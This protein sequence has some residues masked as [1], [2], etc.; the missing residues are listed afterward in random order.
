[1]IKNSKYKI[2]S[3]ILTVLVMTLSPAV[4]ILLLLYADSRADGLHTNADKIQV[5]T[6]SW[7]SLEHET[8]NLL[9]E[10]V[11]NSDEK[12]W[13]H[14]VRIFDAMLKTFLN[15]PQTKELVVKNQAFESRLNKAEQL[16]LTLKDRI[17]PSISHLTECVKAGRQSDL[18]LFVAGQKEQGGL[19]YKMGYLS[20]KDHLQN[21]DD[22]PAQ[23]KIQSAEQD[24]RNRLV[25]LANDCRSILSMSRNHY[26]SLLDE[27]TEIISNRAAEQIVHTRLVTFA[28]SIAIVVFMV[29]FMARMQRKYH[30]N[31]LGLEQL[32]HHH[33]NELASAKSKIEAIELQNEEMNSQLQTSV[34]HANL[35]TQRAMEANRAKN[36]FLTNMSHAIRIPLSAIIGFSEML[37]EEN[38]SDQQKEQVGMIRDSGSQ[39]LQL[40]NDIIDFSKIEMGKISVKIAG[41]NI[42]NIL[43]TVETL[44][45][46]ATQEKKLKFEIIRNQPLPE[47]IQTDPERLKQCLLNLVSNAVKFTEQ[48]RVSVKV[49]WEKDCD[50][51]FV[52]FDVEDTGAGIA[53]GRLQAIFKPFFHT[54]SHAIRK[55]GG[56][57]LGLAITHHLAE[58]LGGRVSVSSVLNQGSVFT[59]CIP[60]QLAPAGTEKEDA[61]RATLAGAKE[62]KPEQSPLQ[63]QAV[64]SEAEKAP[65]AQPQEIAPAQSS[66]KEEAVPE[67]ITNVKFRG[68][69]LIAE[70][71]LTNQALA[72]LLLKKMNLET[73]IVEN[74][75]LAIEK[76]MNE[77][78]DLVLMDIQMPVMNGYE[79]TKA[80]REKG[81]G[82]PIIAL[83]A[84]A[85]KGD[86]EKCFAAGCS[87]YLSKPIDRKK[88]VKT[89]SKYLSK[90]DTDRPETE[91]KE[92]EKNMETLTQQT[93]QNAE[94]QE[95]EID[96]NLLMDRIG[97]E[98]LIDEIIPIFIK[99][100]AERILKLEQAVGKND[101]SEVKFFAHSLKGAAGTVGAAKLSEL[102][103]KLEDDARNSDNSDF[104]PLFEEMKVRF[105]RLIAFF[106]KSDWKEIAKEASS[107]QRAGKS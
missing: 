89:L 40:V 1:M 19:L 81:I 25:Q 5:L 75:E 80:M 82:K 39:L 98:E 16:W 65:A 37:S 85:M 10:P 14:S 32:I 76:M 48:G 8:A 103:K 58:L 46:P 26:T 107:Q 86:E 47:I 3:T 60:T 20:A 50:E 105:D 83:T 27:M 6:D 28:L 45:R 69:V 43:G 2:Y 51:P 87:D 7:H 18:P 30:L 66:A 36:E 64:K 59:L 100:N 34:G 35:M 63:M 79:A 42:E 44:I 33:K 21:L 71:S 72:K 77:D 93:H 49:S 106:K 68:R 55:F 99:D 96:W 24:N 17:E 94:S 73:V 53:P 29:L 41:C 57:G 54:D 22:L 90:A 61:G 91:A 102:G 84:C 38:L 15:N 101:I 31:Q 9:T 67:D 97:C 52:R 92:K 74:G 12:K 13:L 95:L 88:L 23:A 62:E 4:I 11:T 70:D 78:F 56:T 104:K